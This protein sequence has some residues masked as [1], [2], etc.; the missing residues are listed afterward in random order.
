VYIT[1]WIASLVDSLAKTGGEGSARNDLKNMKAKKSLGQNFLVDEAVKEKIL[2]AISPCSGDTILEIGPGMGALTERL[3]ASGADVVAVELDDRLIPI[4][5]AKFVNC[6]N[7][8]IVHKNVLEIDRVS[9]IFEEKEGKVLSYRVV[10]NLP[11]YIASAVIRKFLE[12]ELPPTEMF[13]MVQKE[14]AE[15]ICAKPGDMSVLSVAVQYY[16]EP[17]ILFVVPSEAF[18]P[19]PKVESGFVKLVNSLQFTVHSEENTNFFRLVKMGFAAR[20]KT[21][22]NNL[23]AG[24]RIPKES[25]VEFLTKANIASKARAQDLN[26]AEWASLSRTIARNHDNNAYPK[27]SP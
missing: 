11:Y 21:L 2:A 16:A 1:F 18:D 10:G 4:L 25:A 5:E 23:A 3:V 9:D 19:V 6:K 14:V 27:I 22:A 13:V 20:R 26:V 8:K 12:S 15:R 17:E 24:L 7:V